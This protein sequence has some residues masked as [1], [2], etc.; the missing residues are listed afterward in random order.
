M[1]GLLIFRG[2]LKSSGGAYRYC[3]E[4]KNKTKTLTKD[5]SRML[6]PFFNVPWYIRIH[7][8][9]PNLLSSSLN[10]KLTSGSRELG[11]SSI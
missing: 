4:T 5:V 2:R 9:W 1:H 10:A 3:E 7:V 11:L 6:S 8:N